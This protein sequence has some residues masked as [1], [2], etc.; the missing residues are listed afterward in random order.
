MPTIYSEEFKA[1]A[2]ELLEQGTTQV[3]VCKD[4]G[5]S[6]SAL[7]SWV[8]EARLDQRGFEPAEGT[9][10]KAEQARMLRR[11]R[12]LEQEN[13]ILRQATAYL[14]QANLKPGQVRP[15]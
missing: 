10:G 13:E 11:I 1:S 12:E 9:E 8:N 15:K 14:S 4:L 6:K 2:L 3:Q 5:M 7:Q